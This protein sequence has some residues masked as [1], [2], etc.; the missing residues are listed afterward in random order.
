MTY[1]KATSSCVRF[2]R[3]VPALALYA[4]LGTSEPAR[5]AQAA[6]PVR[7]AHGASSAEVSGAV[8]RGE[9][10][11]YS[12]EARAGQRMSL[13]IAALENNAVFQVYAPGAEPRTGDFALEVAGNTLPGAGEGE[14]TTRWTGVLPQSGTYLLVVG[15][16]RGNAT[17]R[18][19]VEIR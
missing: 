1:S 11:L 14:D 12:V 3:L 7:F 4:G 9:R 15:P 6:E 5:S 18:L 17:Y 2:A 16:T 13:R 19:N 8:I 10:A